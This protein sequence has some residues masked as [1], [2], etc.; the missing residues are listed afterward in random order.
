MEQLILY[1]AAR[2]RERIETKGEFAKRIGVSQPYLSNLL[3]GRSYPSLA[4]AFDI[5]AATDGRVPVSAWAPK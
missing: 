4:L 5:E 2:K 3:A 1:L